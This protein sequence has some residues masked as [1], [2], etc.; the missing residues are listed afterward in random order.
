MYVHYQGVVF[1]IY[2]R[3]GFVGTDPRLQ[4]VVPGQAVPVT[5]VAWDTLVV[6]FSL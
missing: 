6:S 2:L 4:C 5:Y 3:V 1:G